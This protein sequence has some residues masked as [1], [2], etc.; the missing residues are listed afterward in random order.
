ME[1]GSIRRLDRW[2]RVHRAAR[3]AVG[4]VSVLVG[5]MLL[6]VGPAGCDAPERALESV[7]S[8]AN[9]IEKMIQ[10]AWGRR[11]SDET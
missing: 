10:S 1:S 7:T 3:A 2:T 11:S 8:F 6:T 4:I 5:P 9:D